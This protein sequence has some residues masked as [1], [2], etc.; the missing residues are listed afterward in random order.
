MNKKKAQFWC[1]K[2]AHARTAEAYVTFALC[3]FFFFL[4][5]INAITSWFAPAWNSSNESK[6][7]KIDSQLYAIANNYMFFFLVLCAICRK[8]VDFYVFYF[9]FYTIDEIK[10]H[11]RDRLQFDRESKRT[12]VRS[13]SIPTHF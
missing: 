4:A 11:G 12:F 10:Q 3:G 13:L 5:F 7:Q 1:R 2:K 6:A 9:Y 8:K